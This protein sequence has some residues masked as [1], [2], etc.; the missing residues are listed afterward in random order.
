DDDPREFLDNLKSKVSTYVGQPVFER[1]CSRYMLYLTKSDSHRQALEEEFDKRKN[2][3]LSWETC[4]AIFLRV[5]LTEEERINQMMDLLKAGRRRDETYS[6]F[7]MRIA[8]DI[9]VYGIKDDNE[10]VLSLL[11]SAVSNDA[12][13]M[14]L[15]R[16][17]A[18]SGEKGVRRFVSI[19]AF[20]K[21]MSDLIGPPSAS[22]RPSKTGPSRHK[23]NGS[24]FDPKERRP[25]RRDNNDKKNSDRAPFWCKK[26]GPNHSHDTKNHLECEKCHKKGHKAQDCK[27]SSTPRDGNSR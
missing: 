3:Q 2:E 8:R 6:Q 15:I 20:V 24:R 11:A 19:N 14:M 1:T 7:A 16:F 27:S 23:N 5:A 12:L 25:P 18:E 9:K 21:T 17:T 13:N 22:E 26:C 4:E 10:V